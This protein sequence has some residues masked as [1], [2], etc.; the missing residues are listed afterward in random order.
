MNDT[1]KKYLYL[2]DLLA[3]KFSSLGVE[4]MEFDTNTLPEADSIRHDAPEML[5]FIM[6]RYHHLVPFFACR[7]RDSH[8]PGYHTHFTMSL[9]DGGGLKRLR[10][11]ISKDFSDSKDAASG[12]SPL[13]LKAV[14]GAA[15]GKNKAPDSPPTTS[16]YP[17]DE[18][19]EQFIKFSPSTAMDFF[20]KEIC[21]RPHIHDRLKKQLELGA[22]IRDT[23]DHK[24]AEVEKTKPMAQSADERCDALILAGVD[25]LGDLGIYEMNFADRVRSE[26]GDQLIFDLLDM[27]KFYLHWRDAIL[28]FVKDQAIGIRQCGDIFGLAADKTTKHFNGYG[29]DPNGE[30]ITQLRSA[31]D[32]EIRRKI[33]WL[34]GLTFNQ[35][36]TAPQA[37]EPLATSK[38]PKGTKWEEITIRF[39]DGENVLISAH[40]CSW[41]ASCKE[42]G[43]QDDKAR[44]RRANK[45]WL[46]LHALAGLGGQIAWRDKQ[47][48]DKVKK[49]KQKLSEGL[50]E[51]FK[52]ND[53]PF[54]PYK[55][56]KSYR[57]KAHLVPESGEAEVRTTKLETEDD[58]GI[59]E[60]LGRVAK[61]GRTDPFGEFTQG[62]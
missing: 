16:R 15:F 18:T 36:P 12:K 41:E 3:A 49:K 45:Q 34:Q 58:L 33:K 5:G 30:P 25:L 4:K 29:I 42:M 57:L 61:L 9:P 2:I 62:D 37:S 48:D 1:K 53:D 38:L 13:G 56:E 31:L 51:Y 27:K 10:E 35:I 21:E 59:D 20:G 8:A 14:L 46:F 19:I 17:S 24:G 44:P 52:I 40:D 23:R 22:L 47:A 32:Y 50:R 7:L 55:K 39:I 54:Y 60:E 28:K 43:F 26:N 6:E 11:A